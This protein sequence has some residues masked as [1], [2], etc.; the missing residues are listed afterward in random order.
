MKLQITSDA[1]KFVERAKKLG[2]TSA[3]WRVGDH[4]E[5]KFHRRCFELAKVVWQVAFQTR[6]VSPRR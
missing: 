3:T 4:L 2:F 6:A 5:G 1:P